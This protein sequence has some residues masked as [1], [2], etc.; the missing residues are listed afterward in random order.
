MFGGQFQLVA[1]LGQFRQFKVGREGLRTDRKRFRPT[2]DSGC[3]RSIDVLKRLLGSGSGRFIAGRANPV[4]NAPRRRL[5]RNRVPVPGAVLRFI[6]KECVFQGDMCVGWHQAHGLAELFAR[7]VGLAD[8]QVGISKIFTDIRPMRRKAN[9]FR[10][11]RHRPVVIFQLE[12]AIG[13]R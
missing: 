9:G 5:P 13:P 7:Q 6:T 3:K 12:F 11:I 2:L 10:E 1:L 4:E 8:L